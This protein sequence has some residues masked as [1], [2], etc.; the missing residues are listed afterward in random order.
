MCGKLIQV[1]LNKGLRDDLRNSIVPK[2][3]KNSVCIGDVSDDIEYDEADGSG[4]S[5]ETMFDYDKYTS[6]SNSMLINWGEESELS[7]RDKESQKKK[8]E[9]IDKQIELMRKQKKS[10]P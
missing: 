4:H 6:D 5:L 10:P 7:L 3:L 8:F 1:F 9:T 2:Y